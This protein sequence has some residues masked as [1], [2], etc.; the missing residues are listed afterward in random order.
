MDEEIET[1]RR[2]CISFVKNQGYQIMQ[3]DAKPVSITPRHR[4]PLAYLLNAL[5]CGWEVYAESRGLF[6]YANEPHLPPSGWRRRFILVTTESTFPSLLYFWLEPRIT[7]SDDIFCPW[8]GCLYCTL[9]CSFP[10]LVLSM[11]IS[12]WSRCLE[13]W[14]LLKLTQTFWTLKDLGCF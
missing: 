12:Q 1:Q 11:G 14:G 10:S 13:H 7:H 5:W 8:R 9:S 6:L 4:L 2:W 3:S